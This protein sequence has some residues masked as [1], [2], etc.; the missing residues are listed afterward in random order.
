MLLGLQVY[1][2]H[3]KFLLSILLCIVPEVGLLD[4]SIGNFVRNLHTVFHCGYTIYIPTNRAEGLQSLP[5]RT[6][7]LLYVLRFDSNHLSGCEGGHRIFHLAFSSSDL[8]AF[9]DVG[10]CILQLNRHLLMR[11]DKYAVRLIV[12]SGQ[13]LNP[14]MKPGNIFFPTTIK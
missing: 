4:L 8:R 10:R 9:Y 1:K 13:V 2:C 14:L 6:Q 3:F 7:N 12:K 11:M 5:H